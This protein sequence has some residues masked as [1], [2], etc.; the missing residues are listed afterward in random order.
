MEVSKSK[1]NKINKNYSINCKAK[2]ASTTAMS[3]LEGKYIKTLTRSR[4]LATTNNI[5]SIFYVLFLIANGRDDT[6]IQFQTEKKKLIFSSL[7]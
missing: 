1:V 7:Q 5:P 2:S 4:N 6:V 3:D